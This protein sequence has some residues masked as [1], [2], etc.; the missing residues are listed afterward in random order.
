MSRL[1]VL[2]LAPAR[3]LRGRTRRRARRARRSPERLDAELAQQREAS[4]APGVGRRARA[5]R[6][7]RVGGRGGTA[8]TGGRPM[9][10]ETPMAFGSI[11]KTV[12]A[13]VALQLAEQ[14]RIDLDDPVRRWVPEWPGRAGH[15]PPAAALPYERAWPIPAR[16]STSTQIRASGARLH[17]G[18]LDRRAHGAVRGRLQDDAELRQCGLHPRRARDQAGG[19]ARVAAAAPQHGARAGGAAGRARAGRRPAVG[20]W[21]RRLKKRPFPTGGAGMVPSTGMATAAWTAGALA[22]PAPAL[23]RFGDRLLG[24]HLVSAGSL[25]QMTAFR[26]GTAMWSGYGLGLGRQWVDRHEAW[27]HGGDI[28]GFHAELWHLPESDL[29]LSRSP[30]TTTG[31]TTTAS[32]ERCSGSLS[33]RFHCRASGVRHRRVGLHRRAPDPAARGRRLVGQGARALR[34]RGR[35]GGGGRRRAGARRPARRGGA[36]ARRRRRRGGVPRRREGR[37]LGRH[38]RVPPRQRR[39]HEGAARGVPGRRR[40]AHG[41]RR[42]R[43]RAAARAAAGDGRRAHAAGVPFTVAVLVDEGRGRGGGGRRARHRDDRRSPALRLGPRRHDADAR[44]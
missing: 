6:R 31:S 24:G 27:G 10:P 38:P 18:R 8:D 44:R 39:R 25:K 43:G 33:H 34:R 36:A 19:R 35:E 16:T 1:L 21:R 42:H 13:A 29:T 12:T 5:S 15:D 23:A 4:G 41:P 7:A 22:G 9:T 20:Y 14:G 26:D 17:A 30:G 28:P 11:T 37:G 2:A 3:R 40:A 32:S